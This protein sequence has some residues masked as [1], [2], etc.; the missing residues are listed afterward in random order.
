MFPDTTLFRLRFVVMR[1]R[2][3]PINNNAIARRYRRGEGRSPTGLA[4]GAVPQGDPLVPR[5]GFR[6]FCLFE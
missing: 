3:P 5:I 1:L 6:R 4:P 2:E